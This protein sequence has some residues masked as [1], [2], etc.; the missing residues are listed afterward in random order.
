MAVKVT[1]AT[2]EQPTNLENHNHFQQLNH[3]LTNYKTSLT[4]CSKAIF[5]ALFL[6]HL[7][8]NFSQENQDLLTSVLSL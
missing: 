1:K 7:C 8:D 4:A 6:L 2:N 5:S 3:A